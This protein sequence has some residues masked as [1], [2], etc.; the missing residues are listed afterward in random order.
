MSKTAH[1]KQLHE[2]TLEELI[3]VFERNSD[4]DQ[5]WADDDVETAATI[6]SYRGD[7]GIRYLLDYL[8]SADT[9]YAEAVLWAF[10]DHELE[11]VEVRKA[12]LCA[13]NDSRAPVLFAA[14]Y[15]L[16]MRDVRDVLPQIKPLIQHESPA[17]RDAAAKYL[18]RLFPEIALNHIEAL[19]ADPSWI[20]R[21]RVLEELGNTEDEELAK[22]AVP[23]ALKSLD[24]P[25]PYVREDAAELLEYVYWEVK[26]PEELN[27]GRSDPD[28]RM[29]ASALRA[30]A[31]NALSASP[32]VI[33]IGLADTD[34]VVRLNALDEIFEIYRD[35]RRNPPPEMP[36]V[37]QWLTDD[38]PVIREA[39]EAA[40]AAMDGDTGFYAH[41][42]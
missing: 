5:E 12:M 1:E 38:D 8:P 11:S 17:V 37:S 19:R 7:P 35:D 32:D 39:A 41:R 3:E 25:H 29:R 30:S 27:D 15:G 2:M 9:A 18:L 24:D 14:I 10:R 40:A 36:D 33:A 34:R 16:S 26:T 6:L 20:V 22:L 13:V 23:Y 31:H 42:Y 21:E 4:G 28:P